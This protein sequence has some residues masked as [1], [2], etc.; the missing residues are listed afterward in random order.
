MAATT[1]SQ[2]GDSVVAS[3]LQTEFMVATAAQERW[4]QFSWVPE[5]GA[6]APAT[7]ETATT[8]GVIVYHNLDLISSGIAEATDIEGVQMADSTINV[9][10]VEYGNAVQDTKR[11]VALARTDI[12]KAIQIQIGKNAG[13]SQDS[14]ARGVYLGGNLVRRPTAGNTRAQLDTVADDMQAAGFNFFYSLAAQLRSVGAPGVGQASESV[15][16]QQGASEPVVTKYSTV[17]HDLLTGDLL[18]TGGFTPYSYIQ[19]PQLQQVYNGEFA[20]FAGIRLVESPLGKI[21]QSA[22]TTAQATTTLSAALSANDTSAVVASATGLTTGDYFTVGTV[23]TGTTETSTLESVQIHSIQSTTTMHITGSGPVGGFRYAHA[24]AAVVTESNFVAAIPVFGGMSVAKV[25]STAYGPKP[26]MTNTGPFDKL[27]RFKNYGW[28][29]LGGYGR[30]IPTWLIRGEVAV[31]G[32]A[33]MNNF[34]V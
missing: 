16:H 4:D 2:L 27:G 32:K 6:F 23:E 30:T 28:L 13:L 25:Y 9:A 26:T 34:A 12:P 7:S 31:N 18:E 15:T 14:L 17:V 19:T 29:W 24:N 33:I 11:L 22:G 1:T 3:H 10:V 5:N 8:I 20:E 21:Y